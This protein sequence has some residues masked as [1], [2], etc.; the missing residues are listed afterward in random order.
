MVFFSK[1]GYN[2]C[3]TI[4]SRGIKSQHASGRFPQLVS[5][6]LEV[7]GGLVVAQWVATRNLNRGVGMSST[8]II[9]GVVARFIFF[10]F[11]FFFGFRIR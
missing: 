7:G 6:D 1:A 9:H 4:K 11:Y 10:L 3:E 8:L 2:L 5:P